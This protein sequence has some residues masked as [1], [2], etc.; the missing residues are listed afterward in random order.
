MLKLDVPRKTFRKAGHLHQSGTSYQCKNLVRGLLMVDEVLKLCSKCKQLKP[1]SDFR[2]HNSGHA[3]KDGRQQPCRECRGVALKLVSSDPLKK[4]CNKCNQLK[5]LDDF[6]KT[7]SPKANKDGRRQPCKECLG[8]KI[9]IESKDSN[10]KYCNKCSSFK[11]VSEFHLNRCAPDGLCS[12]CKECVRNY[13]AL[14]RE[15]ILRQKRQAYYANWEQE[16]KRAD[17]WKKK[18]AAQQYEARKA[19]RQRNANRIKAYRVAN[20]EKIRIYTVQRRA[21]IRGAEGSFT[22]TEVRELFE[23]QQGK[24]VYCQRKLDESFHR[25]HIV[26]LSRGGSNFISNIQLLCGSCNS[27]K[28]SKTSEEFLAWLERASKHD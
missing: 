21:K 3:A 6:R 15:A 8:I 19:Y 24:C 12:R 11:S 28:H 17:D 16:R 27:S 9:R 10:F 4:Y 7:G 18:N 26:P 13:V 14:N 1:I 5:P 25:D 2:R 20:Q 23:Q 22:V